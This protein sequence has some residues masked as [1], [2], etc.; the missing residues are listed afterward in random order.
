LK[1]LVAGRTKE[2]KKLKRLAQ[3]VINQR[4]EV[5]T[6]L[7]ESLDHVRSQIY[8]SL[9]TQNSSR[10]D[11]YNPRTF[12][13]EDDQ[14]S[15]ASST[16]LPSI[17]STSHSWPGDV[18]G[19]NYCRSTRN[20]RGFETSGKCK[21]H[22][23]HDFNLHLHELDE[24]PTQVPHLLQDLKEELPKLLPKVDI[25]DL[26]WSDREKVLRY[27]FLK[28]NHAR[29]VSSKDDTDSRKSTGRN[30]GGYVAPFTISESGRLLA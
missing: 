16:R 3:R 30:G 4:T 26:S 6:F 24:A 29:T 18:K 10:E 28:I 22:G 20:T 11:Y 12:N 15:N 14:S 21:I 17:R 1:N 5:E 23:H 19:R 25:S 27:L 7:I 13:H 8:A 9:K 2:L